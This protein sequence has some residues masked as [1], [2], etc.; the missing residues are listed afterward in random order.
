MIWAMSREELECYVERIN[1]QE[2]RKYPYSNQ[3]VVC[4]VITPSKDKALSVMKE[5]GAIYRGNFFGRLTWELNNEMWIWVD[6][7]RDVR[8]YRFYKVFIDEVCDEDLLLYAKTYSGGY[9][10]SMEII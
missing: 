5:R 4:A 3:V 8:H 6:Q 9:C 10:C 7:V 2:G 1:S